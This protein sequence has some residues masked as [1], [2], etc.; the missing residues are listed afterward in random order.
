MK[1]PRVDEPTAR[2]AV[3]V[4]WVKFH[5]RS[6]DLAEALGAEARF[7][8]V[9]RI[10][11]LTVPLRHPVQAVLTIAL[12]ARQRPGVVYTMAPPLPL[13]LIGLA[14]ARLTHG[15]LVIDAHSAAVVDRRTGRQ[16]RPFFLPVARRA[17]MTIVTTEVL[18]EMLT[19]RGV[20]AVDLHV[21]PPR[22]GVAT[23]TRERGGRPRVV[24]PSSWDSDEPMT[25]VFEMARR[26]PAVDVVVTGQPK[27]R[28]PARRRLPANLELTGH[29]STDAYAGLL[30][31]SDAILALTTAENTMQQA[32]YE[33]LAYQ[34]PLVTSD[35]AALRTYFTKGTVFVDPTDPDALAAGVTAALEHC[36]ALSKEMA[37]LRSQRALDW[38][39]AVTELATRLGI[40]GGRVA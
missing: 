16:L 30:R 38:S 31:N 28:R 32:G 7:V 26:I 39:T 23:D 20:E 37:A 10:R 35:T 19:A 5:P 6:H 8:G 17:D 13:V 33:A 2:P 34:K 29:L 3:F 27:G 12:L 11:P 21:P 22:A 15:R 4:S 18:A 24:M 14:Y 36:E 9:G 40:G 25:A 1:R